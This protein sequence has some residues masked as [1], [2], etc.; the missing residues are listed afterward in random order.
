MRRRRGNPWARVAADAWMLG[1]DAAAV[2]G[3]RAVKLAAGGRAARTESRR[4]VRE[5]LAAAQSWQGAAFTGELGSSAPVAA[6]R[7][8]RL[9]R[10]KVSAN[11]RRLMKG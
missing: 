9:Y 2:V 3:L 1:V 11:R 7:S 4:M 10:R 5:K 6:A 8:L